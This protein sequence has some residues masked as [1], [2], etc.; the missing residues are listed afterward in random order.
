MSRNT[1][2]LK[3]LKKLAEKEQAEKFKEYMSPSGKQLKRSTPQEVKHA[4]FLLKMSI[5]GNKNVEVLGQYENART[6]IELRCR[7]CVYLWAAI[8]GGLLDG[9]GCPRCGGT[10]KLTDQEIADRLK[11]RDIELIRY[12]GNVDKHSTFKCEIDGHIWEASAFHVFGGTGCPKCAGRLPI[13]VKEFAQELLLRDIEL[14]S[15]AGNVKEISKFRC[16]I[17]GHEWDTK[18]NH[19]RSGHGCPKCANFLRIEEEEFKQELLL[20]NITI[21]TYSGSTQAKSI[22]KCNIDGYQWAAKGS[23]IRSGKGC[24]KCAGNLP[25]DVESFRKQLRERGIQLLSYA[26]T[27]AKHSSFLCLL[28]GHEWEATASSVRSGSGCP[29]CA[30]QVFNILYLLRDN[31]EGTY[32]IGITQS[33]TTLPRRVKQIA[34]ESLDLIHYWELSNNA[35]E[36]EQYLH[37]ELTEYNVYNTRVRSGNTE[38]FNLD[39]L[40]DTVKGIDTLIQ[41]YL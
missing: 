16:L 8:P 9:Q 12:A 17:D 3:E 28:D 19:I 7:K 31:K 24:P 4:A 38:F 21:V 36:V 23:N 37:T 30:G 6:K 2:K 14:I 27:T 35:R 26:G 25:L 10:L 13:C 41:I 5:L 18:A 39:H 29:K 40:G 20:R 22:F 34:T 33:T 1:E 15:Y 32:K 11:G